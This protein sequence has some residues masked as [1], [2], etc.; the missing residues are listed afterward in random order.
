VEKDP[1]H[2]TQCDAALL[3]R[4]RCRFQYSLRT[5]LL[6]FLGAAVALGW[7]GVKLRNARMQS[8]AA[9]DLGRLGGHVVYGYSFRGPG[10]PGGGEPSGPVWVRNLLGDDLF[11]SVVYVDMT[12]TAR[13]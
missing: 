12:A 8:K 1:I 13:L 3:V 10:F 6:V 7:L 2:A 4:Q 5:L 11:H 9:A